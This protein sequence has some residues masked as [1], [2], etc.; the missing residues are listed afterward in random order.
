MS[1]LSA[2]ELRAIGAA[3]AQPAANILR[4]GSFMA[5]AN[6][7]TNLKSLIVTFCLLIAAK[8]SVFAQE[9]TSKVIAKIAGIEITERELALV[10]DDMGQ[11]FA[12]MPDAE[13]RLAVFRALL[14]IKMLAMEAEENGFA[15]DPNFV[16]R[17]AFTRS[18]TLH[19][20]Y[21]QEKVLPTISEETL[22][23][24]YDIEIKSYPVQREIRARHILVK[25]EE[26]ARVI[27]SELDG[28]ADFA[29]LAK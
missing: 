22:K 15:N 7:R 10:E 27:I 20:R 29:A 21:F 12:Q 8:G 28:G 14:D 11:Q 2:R 18:R 1:T 23:E 3:G 6:V 19:N 25:T 17:M 16:A 9:P 4:K 13:R 5:L 24:R 26:E